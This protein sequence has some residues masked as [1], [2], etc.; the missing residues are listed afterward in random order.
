MMGL[1][2]GSREMTAGM[3][4][5]LAARANTIP[6]DARIPNS[7]AGIVIWPKRHSIPAMVVNPVSKT[8][9]LRLRN[10]PFANSLLV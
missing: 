4:N 6:N 10:T 2:L 9:L 1:A 8:G 5:K 3:K 7:R